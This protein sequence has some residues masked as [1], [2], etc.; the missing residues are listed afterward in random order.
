MFYQNSHVR[1]YLVSVQL[2]EK[3]TIWEPVSH[4]IV[5]LVMLVFK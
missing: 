5:Q 1:Y 4:E 3:K 2:N